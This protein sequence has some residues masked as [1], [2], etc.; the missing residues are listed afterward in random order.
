MEKTTKIRAGYYEYKGREI[1]LQ[2]EK[3]EVY[4]GD[5]DYGRWTIT[6][7]NHHEWLA[8]FPTLKETKQAIR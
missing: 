8:T 5:I 3:A 2:D 1:E 4:P 7:N 6:E